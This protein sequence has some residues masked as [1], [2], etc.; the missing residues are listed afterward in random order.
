ELSQRSEKNR[1]KKIDS[2]SC[3]AI[4]ALRIAMQKPHPVWRFA[5][6]NRNSTVESMM[7]RKTPAGRSTR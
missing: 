2:G 4:H 6:S 3:K 5:M 7:H 1:R